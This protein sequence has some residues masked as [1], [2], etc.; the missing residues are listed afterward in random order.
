MVCGD[1]F[2]CVLKGDMEWVRWIKVFTRVLLRARP[3][4][5]VW[6]M[7][8]LREYGLILMADFRAGHRRR[9]RVCCM[10]W[11]GGVRKAGVASGGGLCC[12]VFVVV[13]GCGGGFFGRAWL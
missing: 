7:Y 8:S 13:G 10:V 12:V 4:Q 3:G 2:F 5:S 9:V 11:G 6:S 1:N